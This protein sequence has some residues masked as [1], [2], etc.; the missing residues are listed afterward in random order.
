MAVFTNP[1]HF[2]IFGVPKFSTVAILYN[3]EESNGSNK[4]PSSVSGSFLLQWNQAD[5]IVRAKLKKS[6]IAEPLVYFGGG[7]LSVKCVEVGGHFI[8]FGFES[9]TVSAIKFAYDCKTFK[10]ELTSHPLYL[11]AHRGAVTTL[12]T[13]SEFGIAI[14][15]AKDNTCVVWDMV[16]NQTFPTYVRTVELQT[17]PYLVQVSKTSGDFAVVTSDEDSSGHR[18]DFELMKNADSSTLSLFTINGRKVAERVCEPAITSLAFSTTPEGVSANAI[19]TGHGKKTGV[20]RLWSSWNLEP[21]RD[22]STQQYSPIIA[23]TFS[24]DNQN[25]YAAT[26]DDFVII[27]EKANFTGLKRPPKYLNLAAH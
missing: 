17:T 4:N 25:L 26:D 3:R 9:G 21:L 27:F 6:E 20:I 11:Y 15:A 13:S 18:F 10:L 14:T 22:I 23:L 8:W 5:G 7:S 24:V 19:A 16:K 1:T 12:Y 2:Q